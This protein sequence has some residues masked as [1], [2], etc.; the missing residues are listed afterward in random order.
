MTRIVLLTLAVNV[1]VNIY[2][3]N[4][5][6]VVNGIICVW[7]VISYE[8]RLAISEQIIDIYKNPVR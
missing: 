8:R 2:A 5:S 1:G 3:A 7:L 6:A 4:P